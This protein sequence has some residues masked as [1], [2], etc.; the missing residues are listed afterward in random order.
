MFLN[1]GP[2]S[3]ICFN[4]ILIFYFLEVDPNDLLEALHLIVADAFSF[5]I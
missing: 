1:N 5:I 3:E 2:E 4:Y